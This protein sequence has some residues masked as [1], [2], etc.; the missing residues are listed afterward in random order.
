MD[1]GGFGVGR[2][3]EADALPRQL[4]LADVAVLYGLLKRKRL[5]FT[6]LLNGRLAEMISVC[7]VLRRGNDANG[8][9]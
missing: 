5:V 8:K 9:Q 1:G 4:W 2:Q 3:H 6:D 7:D